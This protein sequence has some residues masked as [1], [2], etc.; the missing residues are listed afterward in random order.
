MSLRDDDP[1]A[2][3]RRLL[4]IRLAWGYPN[5]RD[6]SRFTGINH[7]TWKNWEVGDRL[8]SL[9]EALALCAKTGV[10]LDWIYRGLEHTNPLHVMQRL[11]AFRANPIEPKTRSDAKRRVSAGSS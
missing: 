3:G 6:W 2:V 5:A 7:T 11:Q 9:Q 1:I 10:S 4:E 8:P